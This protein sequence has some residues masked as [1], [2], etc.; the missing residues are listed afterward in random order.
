M[1]F[2]LKE[3]SKT[4]RIASLV[5]KL[6]CTRKKKKKKMISKKHQIVKATKE[7]KEGKKWNDPQKGI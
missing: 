5:Q 3:R 6:G 4:S 1:H 2:Y 7:K